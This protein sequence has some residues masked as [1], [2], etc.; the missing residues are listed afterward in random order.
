[1]QENPRMFMGVRR[2]LHPIR[3]RPEFLW[4]AHNI[5]LTS[6]DN[7]TQLSITN[8]KSTEP[9]YSFVEGES[10][11]GHCTIGNYVILFIHSAEYDTI[12]R[13]DLSKKY[14][15]M[16]YPYK[17]L[18]PVVLYRGNLNFDTEH[19]IQAIGDYE[20]ELVQKV[21][22]VDGKN[23]P[24]VMNISLPEL[25][26]LKSYPN[27]EDSFN[28][29]Y[30]DSPFDFV[31]NMELNENVSI[32][33]LNSGN[34]S[35]PAGVLQYAFTYYY[36]YG[37]ESNIFHTSELLYT[38]YPDRGGSPEDS[39]NNA[40]RIEID[41]ID[42]KFQYLRIY[43]IMR[44]SID[45]M[46]TIKRVADIE[47]LSDKITFID[48]NTTGDIVDPSVLLYIGGKDIVADCLYSKD[49]T[50]FLG[51]I[52]YNRTPI[53]RIG[54]PKI[55]EQGKAPRLN[56]ISPI[57]ELNDIQLDSSYD[58]TN[59]ESNY[60]YVN[61]LSK[62]T[63][64]YKSGETY[65]LGIQAQYKNGEWSEPIYCKD[66]IVDSSIHPSIDNNT[67][68]LRIP[69]FSAEIPEDIK[70]LLKDNEY[71]RVRP[72]VVFPDVKD[73]TILAQGVVCPTVF[74][75]GNRKLNAPYAQSSWI[76]RVDALQPDF[77]E[78]PDT[79]QIAECRHN[80]PLVSGK[81]RCA[82]IQ[83]MSIKD[84]DGSPT[85]S[86]CINNGEDTSLNNT[87]FVDR[88]V[89]TM[90]SPDIEFDDKVQ[91]AVGNSN[92]SLYSVGTV[93]PT[94]NMGD[95][96]I[97]TSTPVMYPDASGFI[98]KTILGDGHGGLISGL[99]Y[100]D[101]IVN[102]DKRSEFYNNIENA[103]PWLIY[104]WHRSGSL[105]NDCV[106]PQGK[107]TRTSVLKKK[108]ISNLKYFNDNHYYTSANKIGTYDVQLFD[109]NEV[110]LV[111]LKSNNKNLSYYGNVD[112]LIP[113]F[114]RF[115]LAFVNNYY[116]K[117]LE[118][119]LSLNG[120]TSSGEKFTTKIGSY[121]NIIL[122]ASGNSITGAVIT[123]TIINVDVS[124]D[125]S[126]TIKK[127]VN[128]KDGRLT[129][130]IKD[131]G[132]YIGSIVNAD[133]SIKIDISGYTSYQI[134]YW[135][136]S[137]K[138]S[139]FNPDATNLSYIDELYDYVGDHQ[140]SLKLAKDGVR[141]K[142][143]STP[144]AVI[145]LHDPLSIISGNIRIVE[146][147][148]EVIEER[149]FGGKTTEALR[150]NLWIPAGPSIRTDSNDKLKWIWGDTWYQR[151]DCLKTYPFTNM[152][153]NQL[154]EI[155]SFLLETRVNIDGRYDR[156]RGNFSNI[157]VT[158]TNFN[159]INPVYSQKN[160]F[161]NYRI[162]DEDYYKVNSYPNQVLYTGVKSPASIQDI[163][164]NLHTANSIDLDGKN[165]RVVSLES[166]GNTLLGFQD[167]GVTNILFN[168]RVQVN[169]SDGVPIEIA[170][171]QKIGGTRILSD[172]IG[173]QDKFSVL[174]TPSG[175]YFMDNNNESIYMFNESLT[176]LGTNLGTLYW[177]RENH[178]TDTW[179]F[180]NSLS[181]DNYK[182]GVRLY[183]DS[184]Y[185][186]IYFI[187][188]IDSKLQRD[189]LC[190]SEQ[191]GQFSSMMSYGGSVMFSVNSKSYS[192]ARDLEHSNTLTLWENFPENSYSY[193][194]IFGEI[195]PFS[196]SFISNENI[197]TKIFD[198]IE[199]RADQY[200]N[201]IL[202]GDNYSTTEQS[203]QPLDYISV[204][205]E[206]QSS[207]I[208]PFNSDTLRKKFR[209]WRA[210]FPRVGSNNRE[211][212]RN[213]WVKVTLGCNSPGNKAT[214]L[215]DISVKYTV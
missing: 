22:W 32:E 18:R 185:K 79:G 40:F 114:E 53:S 211:R 113:S 23:R 61:Q 161:F 204:D 133:S 148:Q 76:F 180:E 58:N 174:S 107:G 112:T 214:I 83:N 119:Q 175:I 67:G 108:V 203:G 39:I 163:W 80:Y 149:R 81:T 5:R 9:I 95:I 96:N 141:M 94:L 87:F 98:H 57:S 104:L 30:K 35:F 184:K 92:V 166:F 45:A 182:N 154:V 24:R 138:S 143:K 128:F 48:T 115:R 116:K 208:V 100:E 105:N 192:I 78:N 188:G 153:E 160:S 186:D 28:S 126:S 97:E 140:T 132:N 212:I 178:S 65:R 156:N 201:G 91:L 4:D 199:I 43:S 19:M 85:L 50:L 77:S 197:V 56:G 209:I 13:F 82:E 69:C 106:R 89:I 131:D 135:F 123:D 73:R 29:I 210:L 173:C 142:Y 63:S 34:G 3:Q 215:H 176:D 130:Y 86:E 134:K 118:G 26:E 213:P 121:E 66:C 33:R 120:T 190:F 20:A 181:D 88:S 129:I 170:N 205:N 59:F 8:E 195:R 145:S 21:Y 75:Y 194:K 169:S 139:Y 60:I 167:H 41:N 70:K 11:I 37:Q 101:A 84:R 36:K 144:H 68:L 207:G 200:V 196:F 168:S 16:R 93:T 27:G 127:D 117:I 7:N 2:D 10:Y 109:S 202:I 62:N 162:L 74:C 155:G 46:P 198:S 99:F 15:S 165:G 179:K 14:V 164:T 171:S 206:Y 187:P 151:Y 44:T 6:R 31:P 72:V 177:C 152:D 150:N 12:Y 52:K 124:E 159:Q 102:D 47:I 122:S 146:L 183:Y 158:S 191:L 111:K 49:N 193:N 64:G 71:K 42:R 17:G 1:M 157:Y 25:N 137:D 125:G 172:T 103:M 110:S 55:I 38:A 189:A 147:R 51:N 136:D 90:H 54:L